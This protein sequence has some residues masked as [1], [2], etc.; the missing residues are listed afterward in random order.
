M[1]G[2]SSRTSVPQARKQVSSRSVAGRAAAAVHSNALSGPQ[3]HAGAA[4]ATC[5]V[6]ETVRVELRLAGGEQR[7]RKEEEEGEKKKEEEE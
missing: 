3:S 2:G 4:D 7:R 5:C 6:V 1:K